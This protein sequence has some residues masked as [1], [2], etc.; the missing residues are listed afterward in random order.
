MA[1]LVAKQEFLLKWNR[2]GQAMPIAFFAA[3]YS[4]ARCEAPNMAGLM[5]KQKSHPKVASIT[6]ARVS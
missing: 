2:E 6:D 1:G 5:R 4:A 3:T